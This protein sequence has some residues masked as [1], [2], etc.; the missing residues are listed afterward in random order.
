MVVV[1]GATKY[2]G[3]TAAVADL[4]F[5][6][7]EGEVVGLLGLNGAGKT[8]TLAILSGL[9]QPTSGRVTVAGI[10]MGDE[11]EAIRTRVGFLPEKP[12]LY[13]EMQ[14]ESYLR[15]VARIK[16]VRNDLET[17]VENAVAA[18]YLNDVRYERIGTLS[19]G[20]QKRVGIAQAIVHN[21][22]LILLDEPS[23]GLDPV[24][25]VHMRQLIRGLRGKNTILVSSHILTE[26]HEL[27]DRI[28]VLQDGRVVA[29]G[30]E[31]ELSGRLTGSTT[32]SVEV[33]GGQAELAQALARA[34]QVARHTVDREDAGITYATV[35]LKND[36]REDLAKS[37]VEAGLGLRRLDQVSLEL[38]NIFL[39]LTQGGTPQTQQEVRS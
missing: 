10:D 21:P 3:E 20:F 1:D 22:A 8:T 15:F 19:H 30:T 16:G 34:G 29:E 18:T 14:V 27:C 2:Y 38:E 31:Q 35:E 32:V 33:R 39:Q 36:S 9:L 13:P 4:S 11:P 23:N 25:V 17:A 28:F 24:Q 6:I 37:L 7:A 12:P 5:S 26:I